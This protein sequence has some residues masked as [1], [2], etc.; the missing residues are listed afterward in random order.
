MYLADFGSVRPGVLGVVGPFW[1]VVWVDCEFIVSIL[2]N[3]SGIL[4]D[5]ESRR[6]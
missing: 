2:A 4:R 5:I 6:L 1:F 3:C